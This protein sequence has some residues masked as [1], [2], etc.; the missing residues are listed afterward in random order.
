MLMV[1]SPASAP[2]GPG[3]PGGSAMVSKASEPRAVEVLEDVGSILE[4]SG[5]SALIS[6]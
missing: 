3:L 6:G 1:P 2:G 4:F 5:F